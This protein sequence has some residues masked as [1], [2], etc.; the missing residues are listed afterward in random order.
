MRLRRR[1]AV[2]VCEGLQ[3]LVAEIMQLLLGGRQLPV[4]KSRLAVRAIF[5]EEED[6]SFSGMMHYLDLSRVHV[7]SSWCTCKVICAF[8]PSVASARSITV[9]ALHALI[10]CWCDSQTLSELPRLQVA[11]YCVQ[12]VSRCVVIRSVQFRGATFGL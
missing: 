2:H 11:I 10:R 9:A 7:D 3:A 4:P 12:L 6:R 1:P 8:E 5:D